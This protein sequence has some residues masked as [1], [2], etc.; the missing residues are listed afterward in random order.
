MLGFNKSTSAKASDRL[1]LAMDQWKIQPATATEFRAPSAQRSRVHQ[2]AQENDNPSHFTLSWN[3]R[4]LKAFMFLVIPIAVFLVFTWWNSQTNSGA[5]TT[6]APLSA[7]SQESV[8]AH[9]SGALTLS[10]ES[11]GSTGSLLVHVAGSVK[12]PGLYQVPLGSR[13]ADAIEAAGGVSKKSASDSVN[14]AREVV[15]GEQIVVGVKNGVTQSGISIN[16]SSASEL[17]E[18]PGVGPVLAERIISYR[19]SNG[20]FQSVDQLGEVSGIGDSILE[21]IRTLATL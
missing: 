10:D 18:L 15:D 14:L 1:R 13:V 2:S 12:S 4:S 5:L 20:P 8:D 7:N 6:G 21:Q 3:R 9:E 19:N 17:E 11:A 16:N